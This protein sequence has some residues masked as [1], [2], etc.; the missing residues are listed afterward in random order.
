MLFGPLSRP[1]LTPPHPPRN[2]PDIPTFTAHLVRL[3]KV[4]ML[5]VI[6][7]S[8]GEAHHL[9]NEERTSLIVES[10]KALDE[11]GLNDVPIIAGT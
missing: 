1:N 4:G 9:T 5:P 11:A 8:M 2:P 6:S 3:A 10:R 7:G